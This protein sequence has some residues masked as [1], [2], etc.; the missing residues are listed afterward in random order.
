MERNIQCKVLNEYLSSRS[1]KEHYLKVVRFSLLEFIY[2]IT[3]FNTS[4]EDL[5]YDDLDRYY[6]IKLKIHG[7]SP[8][9][10][11]IVGRAKAFLAYCA[12]CGII[13]KT[14]SLF[15]TVEYHS[16]FMAMK[17]SMNQTVIPESIK[18]DSTDYDEYFNDDYI[19][20]FKKMYKEAQYKKCHGGFDGSRLPVVD[21][22]RIFIEYYQ[23]SATEESVEYW[24]SNVISD[25]YASAHDYQTTML[26]YH[27]MVT[28]GSFSFSFR[29]SHVTNYDGIPEWSKTMADEYISSYNMFVI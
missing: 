29:R 5:T 18:C 2:I 20:R 3:S 19:I 22:F 28:E 4:I 26:R 23:L 1:W 9:M 25:V 24:I 15:L 27:K 12:D 16:Y 7:D 17:K 11:L 6:A 14:L 10:R 8:S 21:K 13:S